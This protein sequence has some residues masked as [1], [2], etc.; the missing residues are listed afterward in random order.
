MYQLDRGN[1]TEFVG[2]QSEVMGWASYMLED[3]N[4]KH[5]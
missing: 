3:N 1:A 5:P 2:Y 4:E